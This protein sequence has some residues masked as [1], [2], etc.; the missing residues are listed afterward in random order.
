MLRIRF[1]IHFYR[2]LTVVMRYG[3]LLPFLAHVLEQ[4]AALSGA[5]SPLRTAPLKTMQKKIKR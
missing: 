1:G 5:E 4:K 2:S 3:T